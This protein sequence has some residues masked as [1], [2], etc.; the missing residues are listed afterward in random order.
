MS[1]VSVESRP[2]GRWAVQIEGA[3]R[4]DSVHDQRAAAVKRGRELAE[5]TGAEL[6]IK[7]SAGRVIGKESH[8][9]ALM[10][11]CADQRRS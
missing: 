2:G 3:R 5:K 10:D 9:S 1:Q 11:A 4:A 7:N 8:G 6:I